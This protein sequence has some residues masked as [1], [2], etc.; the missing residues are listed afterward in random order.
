MFIRMALW[1]YTGR[2]GY[3]V[4]SLAQERVNALT[5]GLGALLSVVGLVVL[6]RTSAQIGDPSIVVGLA[7]FGGAMIFLYLA[8][9]LYH[10]FRKSGVKHLFQIFDHIGIFLLIAGTYTAFALTTLRNG[11]GLILLIVVWA[12]AIPG[13]VMKALFVNRWP[14]LSLAVYLL[15]GWLICLVWGPLV[16]AGSPSLLG[17]LVAGGVSYTLG[18]IFFVLG[19]RWGWFHP[20]WHVFV[21][22][23]TVCHFFAVMAALSAAQIY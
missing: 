16:H 1:G 9:F 7:V 15:M 18:T 3:V 8:S 5:H 11:P 12:I 20:V 2:M 19:N 14:A 10:G 4:A 21:L 13:I 17:F 6:L 22:G 23:G